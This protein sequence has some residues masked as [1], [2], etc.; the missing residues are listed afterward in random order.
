MYVPPDASKDNRGPVDTHAPGVHVL[1]DGWDAAAEVLNDEAGVREAVVAAAT[2]A[3]ATVV[4]VCV[5]RYSPQGVTA[6]AT[7]AESHLAL[8]TWPEHGYF[9]ADLFYCGTADA[10]DAVRVLVA[11]LGAASG[12]PATMDDPRSGALR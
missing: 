11:A 9:A 3:G 5:H 10:E 4:D 8:H 7:L 6:V 2:A 1:I 12:G